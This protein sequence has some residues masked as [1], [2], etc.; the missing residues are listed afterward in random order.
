[1]LSSGQARRRIMDHHY[2]LRCRKCGEE[3]RGDSAA[4]KL[5]AKCARCKMCSKVIPAGHRQNGKVFCSRECASLY[6]HR[7]N[8]DPIE[9]DDMV[10]LGWVCGFLE[11]EG[12]FVAAASSTG[13][14]RYPGISAAQVQREPL[15][16]LAT[17]FGGV[18]H[19]DPRPNRPKNQNP[20]HY[21]RV[22]GLRA[23]AIMK[24]VRPH[25]SPRRQS[26]IDTALSLAGDMA[27]VKLNARLGR[28]KA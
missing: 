14:Y 27:I 18:V 20:V 7:G 23:V 26:Q 4:T 22:S 24:L 10:E 8:A 25:L 19:F 21:W 6:R 11:G 5:C 28:R 12:A 2:R 17:L 16:R 1:M 3:F 9:I 15:D 13:K